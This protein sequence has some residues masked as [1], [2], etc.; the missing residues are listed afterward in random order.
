MK[1]YIIISL[2]VVPL[3]SCIKT[4]DFDDEGF[5]DQLVLNSIISTDSVFTASFSKSTSILENDY[6]SSHPVIDGALD[7]YE[8]DQLLAHLNSSTGVFR[9]PG[10]I[11]R[12]GNTYKAVATSRG[13]QVVAQTTLPSPADVVAID[14][15]IVENSNNNKTIHLKIQLNDAPGEDY[16]RL[17]LI[18]EY[19]VVIRYPDQNNNKPTNTYYLY[20][21][22]SHIQ[23]DDPV[24]KSVYNN[25]G[26]EVFDMGPENRYQIFPDQLFEGKVHTVKV[27][28]TYFHNYYNPGDPYLYGT[29]RHIYDRFTV[30]VQHLSKDL[31]NYLKYLELYDYYHDNPIAEPVPV[32]SNIS[33][34]AGILAGYNSEASMSI[35]K[36]YIPYSMDTIQ[37]KNS[38]NGGGYGG[39][40]Y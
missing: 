37:I 34:G 19:L 32:Y 29:P 18:H 33:N 28:S 8:N 36:T 27:S 20:K 5:A 40:G 24:F 17:T 39:Y 2:L 11:P 13:R 14:T 1:K 25:S 22:S 7:L 12:A 16:Y 23:S 4:L 15:S 9:A 31:Y 6:G 30:Y 10:I 35:E 26:E 38:T 21:E 3:L